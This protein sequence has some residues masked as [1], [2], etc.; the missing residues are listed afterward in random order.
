MKDS[1][2]RESFSLKNLGDEFVLHHHLGLGDTI[3]CNGLVNFL[4][5][6][7]SKIYLPVKENLFNTVQFLYSE[8]KKLSLFKI[9][10]ESR[11]EDIDEFASS[12]N[13]K[14]LR[15][16]YQN[17]KDQPFNLAFY[18]QLGLPYRYSKKYFNIPSDI[19]KE[20]LLKEHLINFYNVNPKSYSIIHNEYQFP[21]G[22]FDLKFTDKEN[23]IYVSKESDL[24]MNLFL[25]KGLIESAQTIH[26]INSSFLHL[27]E[28]VNKR[29]KLY[30]HN[31][32]KNNLHL[33]NKWTY[34]EYDD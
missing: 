18:K 33:S 5:T 3:I 31:L 34:V 30:Y 12:K 24:F 11:E 10:N 26:C 15:V 27:V 28:R 21:G 1:F 23:A 14:I 16:G 17:V 20:I 6:K 9:S 8:N 2:Q 19:N 4:S 7:Y 29:A 32:R 22:K 25:Y 13:L